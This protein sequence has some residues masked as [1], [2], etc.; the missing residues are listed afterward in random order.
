MTNELEEKVKNYLTKLTSQQ[1]QAR[2]EQD[3]FPF[4]GFHRAACLDLA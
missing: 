1:I 4:F 2:I 3:L